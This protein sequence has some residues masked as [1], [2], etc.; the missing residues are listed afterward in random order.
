[1]E[2]SAAI[3]VIKQESD[4][5]DLLPL[6]SSKVLV[7]PMKEVD[8]NPEMSA[9]GQGLSNTTL[10]TPIKTEVVPELNYPRES[11]DK[12]K[13]KKD[14][15]HEEKKARKKERKQEKKQKTER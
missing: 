1:M 14:R 4:R 6:P 13:K 9:P 2:W 11:S 12:K 5:A 15:S 10:N 3:P 7:P 8:V